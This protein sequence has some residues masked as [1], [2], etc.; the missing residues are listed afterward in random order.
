MI[1]KR[2]KHKTSKLHQNS[3]EEVGWIYEFNRKK[4][5]VRFSTSNKELI[6]AFRKYIMWAFRSY[7]AKKIIYQYYNKNYP[8]KLFKLMKIFKVNFK[9]IVV[10]QNLREN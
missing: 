5:D 7:W 2:L 3:A 1:N 4:Y 8:L 9:G 6:P 10:F